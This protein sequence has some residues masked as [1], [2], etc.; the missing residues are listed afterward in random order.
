MVGQES[1]V[2]S[3]A[4]VYCGRSTAFGSGRFV[5]RI[6][7]DD[8]WMCEECQMEGNDEMTAV[9]VEFPTASV[10]P[11]DADTWDASVRDIGSETDAAPYAEA[12]CAGRA[13]LDGGWVVIG[14]GGVVDELGVTPAVAARE[15]G[16]RARACRRT[17][18]RLAGEWVRCEMPDGV[19]DVAWLRS[20]GLWLAAAE[21]WDRA[22]AVWTVVAARGN[23][24]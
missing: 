8:G 13:L 12:W 14:N 7:A 11:V 22:F 15:C 23:D 16:E 18:E 1:A 24:D 6:P 17:G 9:A 10:W 20:A 5:N 4:C 2:L 19:D 21:A 3:D